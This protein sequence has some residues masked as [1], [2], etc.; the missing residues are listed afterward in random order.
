MGGTY[1]F[2]DL[3]IVRKEGADDGAWGKVVAGV[4]IADGE[5]VEEDYSSVDE[6]QNE[7]T[8]NEIR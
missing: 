1:G 7:S 8:G 4:S 3:E 2:K 6:V 5:V